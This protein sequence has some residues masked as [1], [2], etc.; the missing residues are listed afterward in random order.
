[1]YLGIRSYICACCHSSHNRGSSSV[2]V[3]WGRPQYLTARRPARAD[4]QSHC[5]RRIRSR[6]FRMPSFHPKSP[7]S[8]GGCPWHQGSAPCYGACWL[9]RNRHLLAGQDGID[10]ALFRQDDQREPVTR[11]FKTWNNSTR[12]ASSRICR[13]KLV[14][15][16]RDLS[17]YACSHSAASSG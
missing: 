12:I 1:L 16:C 3:S 9:W 14:M 10:L 4:L 8:S 15:R 6:K 13:I 17:R 5:Q 11:L 7:Q 2:A